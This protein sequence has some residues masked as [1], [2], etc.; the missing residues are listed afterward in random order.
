MLTDVI[1]DARNEL[2]AT[3]RLVMQRAF[4]HWRELD[5][6]MRWCDRQIRQHVRSGSAA[7][8][9][10]RIIGIGELCA[11]AMTAGVGDFKQFKRGHRIGAWLGI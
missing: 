2:S 6:Q 11:S 4:E 5:G 1:E 10:A 7:K 3:A 9:A 8:R